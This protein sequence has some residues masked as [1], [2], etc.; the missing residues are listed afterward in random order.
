[1]N[2]PLT[3]TQALTQLTIF[4]SQTANF[5]F[6]QD[7]LTQA[8]QTAWNDTY[9]CNVVWDSSLSFVLGTY[10]YPLP[11]TLTTVRGL[12]FKRTTSDSPEPIS[13]DLYEVVAGNLQFNNQSRRWLGSTYTLYIKGLY[14]LTTSDNLTSDNLVN[15]VINLAAE[16]LLNNLVLKRTFVFLRNDTSLSDIVRALQTVQG[17]VLRYKQAILREFEAA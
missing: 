12:Y 5:T 7:E 9:V 16:I 11:A 10:Q 3:F 4:T 17:Q 1:M 2:P 13:S 14:K 6:N 8:L 15:Y